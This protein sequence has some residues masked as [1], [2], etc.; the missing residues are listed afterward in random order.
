MS[1]LLSRVYSN[2]RKFTQSLQDLVR[3]NTENREYLA[4]KE[5]RI[6]WELI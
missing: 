6:A 5:D 3:K 1:P 4:I 2:L